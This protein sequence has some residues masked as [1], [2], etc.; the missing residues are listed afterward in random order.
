[1]HLGLNP[2]TVIYF[3]IF[4]VDIGDRVQKGS[5]GVAGKRHTCI[6]AGF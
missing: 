2:G 1:M 5:M 3:A 6:L 4:E